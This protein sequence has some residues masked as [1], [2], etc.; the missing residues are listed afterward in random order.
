MYRSLLQSI[1]VF[2]DWTDFDGEE[3]RL[4]FH[5]SVFG[6]VLVHTGKTPIGMTARMSLFH[7]LMLNCSYFESYH[8]SKLQNS[9]ICLQDAVAVMKV[10]KWYVLTATHYGNCY[11]LFFWKLVEDKNR[12]AK[13]CP[14]LKTDVLYGISM[15]SKI[16][17]LAM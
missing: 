9:I 16:A 5:G 13:F 3:L 1:I 4:W 15:R 14:S 10:P 7:F 12:R 2:W 11:G 6:Q 8:Q 17:V